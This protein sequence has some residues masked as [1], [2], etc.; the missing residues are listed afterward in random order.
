MNRKLQFPISSDVKPTAVLVPIEFSE[1]FAE[2]IDWDAEWEAVA[3]EI[4]SAWKSKKSTLE[5]LTE[6]RIA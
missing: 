4:D 1:E 2:K 5:I 3:K 6:M